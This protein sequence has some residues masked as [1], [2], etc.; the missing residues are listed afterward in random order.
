MRAVGIYLLLIGILVCI[1]W[2]ILPNDMNFIA[3]FI[4]VLVAIGTI[5]ASIIALYLSTCGINPKKYCVINQSLFSIDIHHNV[6]LYLEIQNK[7]SLPVRIDIIELHNTDNISSPIYRTIIESDELQ[8]IQCN[9]YHKHPD[10]S[11]KSTP[12]NEQEW[13]TINS[14]NNTTIVTIHTNRGV[15][16]RKVCATLKKDFNKKNYLL[17]AR[18]IKNMPQNL[19][20]PPCR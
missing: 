18:M 14:D 2:H 17:N 13:H 8:V 3:N 15:F 7:N 9:L 20:P 12:I 6:Y 11:G 1:I 16:R 5:S 19:T 4:N 10:N